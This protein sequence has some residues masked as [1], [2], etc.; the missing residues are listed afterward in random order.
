MWT[1]TL[2]IDQVGWPVRIL[3]TEVYSTTT[4]RRMGAKL[5]YSH[6]NHT[7]EWIQIAASTKNETPDPFKLLP[8]KHDSHEN[9]Y[10]YIYH[11]TSSTWERASWTS[12]CTRVA[13]GRRVQLRFVFSSAA[14]FRLFSG[15]SLISGVFG[16]EEKEQWI[17]S[18]FIAREMTENVYCYCAVLLLEPTVATYT[19]LFSGI[20][21]TSIFASSTFPSEVAVDSFTEEVLDADVIRSK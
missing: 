17:K 13:R 20:T 16:E 10:I 21:L 5:Y 19:A 18:S 12:L 8:C 11:T 14:G 4:V 9:I 1:H 6:H 15:I 2:R 7:I 3:S